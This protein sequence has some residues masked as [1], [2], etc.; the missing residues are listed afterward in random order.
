MV[1]LAFNFVHFVIGSKEIDLVLFKGL[2]KPGISSL[3]SIYQPAKRLLMEWT[4]DLH[5][6]KSLIVF[7][8]FQKH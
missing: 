4:D 3:F 1:R 2:I 6:K 7:L 5:V 8:H